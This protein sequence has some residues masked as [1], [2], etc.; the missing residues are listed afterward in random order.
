MGMS[1]TK[2]SECG[3]RLHSKRQARKHYRERH[4]GEIETPDEYLEKVESEQ[5][6]FE[7]NEP[8]EKGHNP[9]YLVE[10][11]SEGN[12]SR[13]ATLHEFTREHDESIEEYTETETEEHGE[14]N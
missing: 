8:T 10:S 3:K 9:E 11:D 14:D 1:L 6:D 5:R 7:G 2:C 12:N 13:S 4:S